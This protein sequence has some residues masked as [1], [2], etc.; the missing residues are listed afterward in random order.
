MSED[1]KGPRGDDEDE[2]VA[3]VFLLLPPALLRLL[4]LLLLLLREG[5]GEEAFVACVTA[6]IVFPR[7]A[8]SLTAALFFFVFVFNFFLRAERVRRTR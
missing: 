6:S 8:E 1:R 2:E 7:A 3:V 5:E 4:L